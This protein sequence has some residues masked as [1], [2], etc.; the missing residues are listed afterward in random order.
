MTLKPG[1]LLAPA[2]A[3]GSVITDADLERLPEPVARFLRHSRVVGSAVPAVV[4]ARQRGRIRR[5]P[6]ASWIPVKAVEWYTTNPPGLLWKASA[7]MAGVVPAGVT[8]VYLEG[9][10]S[11][12]VKVLGLFTLADQTGVE[13]DRASLLRW[14][15][16]A[17]WFPAVFATDA[18]SWGSID[19]T[20][21]LV[22]IRDRGLTVS[23]EF[24][25]AGDGRVVDFVGE[26][27]R[28]GDGM[29]TWSTPFSDEVIEAGGVLVPAAGSGL[30]HLPE[31]P[32][33]YV[34]VAAETIDYFTLDEA[35]LLIG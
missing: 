25:F 26:R 22:T 4:R 23:G 20:S 34:Q 21:A 13:I 12:T 17:V 28:D 19:D 3:A 29:R 6:D 33:E 31:G 30:W 11:M 27:F 15:Q 5:T 35:R 10:G 7:R 32:F 1:D 2:A 24:R 14:L 8:D 9:R 18:V 16:E